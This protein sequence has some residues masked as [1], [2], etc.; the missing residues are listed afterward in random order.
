MTNYITDLSYAIAE[1]SEFVS[2]S[3]HVVLIC[4]GL[5][6]L[7]FPKETGTLS[8]MRAPSDIQLGFETEVQLLE[9][10]RSWTVYVNTKNVHSPSEKSPIK[11]FRFCEL[12]ILA[13]L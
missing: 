1:Y 6:L 5:C 8:L 11:N 13:Y 4:N 12:H 9:L 3:Y 7:F 2:I 10:Y